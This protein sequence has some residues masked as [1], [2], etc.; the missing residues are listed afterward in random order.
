[1]NKEIHVWKIF[2][3]LEHHPTYMQFCIEQDQAP[4]L[5]ANISNI[6]ANMANFVLVMGPQSPDTLVVKDCF[7]PKHFVLEN[8][9]VTCVFNVTTLQ[10]IVGV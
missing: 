8:K 2:S 5:G 6:P 7:F 4:I 1:M 3:T 9:E 10:C